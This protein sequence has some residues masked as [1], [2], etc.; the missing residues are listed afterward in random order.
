MALYEKSL[1]LIHVSR[2]S[3]T[4][5][6][7]KFPSHSVAPNKQ[8]IKALVK[9]VE[10]YFKDVNVLTHL[11]MDKMVKADGW[12]SLITVARTI[13]VG[14]LSNNMI[15]AMC[16][17]QKV[18]ISSDAKSLRSRLKLS[19]WHTLIYMRSLFIWQ[20][21]ENCTRFQVLRDVF[22]KVGRFLV[23]F[24]LLIKAGDIVPYYLHNFVT[25]VQ[26][27]VQSE[28]GVVE[29]S[30]RKVMLLAEKFINEKWSGVKKLSSP[31]IILW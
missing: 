25:K 31:N 14:E 1:D 21:L 22:E 10:Y 19:Q 7:Y 20:L 4:D 8:T 11:Y 13:N 2:L 15:Y 17:S 5:L 9:P 26:D 6:S 30:S 12:V 29:F 16:F 27:L 28:C 24:T 23:V 18:E 3:P